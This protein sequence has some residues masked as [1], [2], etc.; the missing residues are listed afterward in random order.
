MA[1]V[2][3]AEQMMHTAQECVKRQKDAA[4]VASSSSGLLMITEG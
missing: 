2:A 4:G 3:G 1:I